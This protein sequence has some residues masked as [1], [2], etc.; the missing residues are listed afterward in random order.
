MYNCEGKI[1]LYMICSALT[2]WLVLP[3]NSLLGFYIYAAIQQNKY[4]F[5]MML[6]RITKCS[7]ISIA[8]VMK[9]IL[10]YSQS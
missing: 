6:F 4:L 2:Q 10:F 5:Y 9:K 8:V 7:N 3:S 1:L